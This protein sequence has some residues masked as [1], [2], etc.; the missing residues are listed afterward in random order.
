MCVCVCV[1]VCVC[2]VCV[3]V[4]VGAL[5]NG[6]GDMVRLRGVWSQRDQEMIDTLRDSAVE[7]MGGILCFYTHTHT[8]TYTHIHALAARPGDD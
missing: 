2:A 3:C 8:H 6:L 5:L 7:L 4:C 1:C